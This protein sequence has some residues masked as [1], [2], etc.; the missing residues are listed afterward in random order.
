MTKNFLDLEVPYGLHPLG[1]MVRAEEAERDV[2]YLCPG[3]EEPLVFRAG[4]YKVKHF[5]HKANTQ[6]TGES[7]IHKTA[8]LLI[9]QT[10]NNQADP[11]KRRPI[12]IQTTCV[13]CNS[14][15]IKSLPYDMF[16][17]VY[18]EKSIGGYICD[19]VAQKNNEDILAIEILFSHH[20]DENKAKKLKIRWVELSA[21]SVL[22]NPHYW[23]PTQYKL[24]PALCEKCE[25]HIVK[26]N[27]IIAKFN[28]EP[29]PAAIYK[30][31]TKGEY[32]AE[33]EKCFSC[34]QE[35][36]VYW[37][38][39]VPF[40]Q[41]KPPEPKPR[42]INFKFSKTYQGLY[43]AN[44]CPNCNATQ[45]DNFLFLG[46]NGRKPVFKGLPLKDTEGMKQARSDSMKS[47]IN[48]MLRNI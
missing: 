45:G 32:L 5:S 8:K 30:D 15:A 34:K 11:Q 13:C 20:V 27:E 12:K 29:C 24:R 43:W 17:S 48:H 35:I 6:C 2:Q 28:H 19:V 22:L 40:C 7:I 26:L 18:E 37:W 31:P 3:C 10:I 1:Y 38:D 14:E 47:V 25:N 44:T 39:G 46:V 42:T 4:E 41:N 16:T 23:Q 36:P 33:I 21:E 9:V